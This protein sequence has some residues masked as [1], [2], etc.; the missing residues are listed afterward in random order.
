MTAK[1]SLSPLRPLSTS[2]VSISQVSPGGKRRHLNSVN[3][4]SL[5]SLSLPSPSA[6][7]IHSST[8]SSET[9]NLPLLLS[10]IK[11]TPRGELSH[12]HAFLLNFLKRD[13]LLGLPL[14]ISIVIL[15]QLDK[16][17]L[18]HCMMVCKQWNLLINNTPELWKRLIFRDSLITS[19]EEFESDYAALEQNGTKRVNIPKQMYKLRYTVLKRWMDPTFTPHRQVLEGPDLNVI[20]CLQFDNEKI[21]AGSNSCQILIYNTQSGEL[22]HT[23]LGH[24]GG[25]WAMKFYG[26]I[27]ASGSTDRTVR[28]WNTRTGKCTHIFKGHTSTVRCLEIVQPQ[29]IGT[30]VQGNP[31]MFPEE[32]MLVS[33]SRDATLYLWKLPINDSDSEAPWEFDVGENPYFVNVLK[34]HLASV[35]TVTAYANLVISGSYDSTVRVWDISTCECKYTL[36]GH[37][38]RIY[39]VVYDPHRHRCYSASVDNTVRIWD[40]ETGE[41]LHILEGH[42]ILVGLVTASRNALV[43]AAADSTVRVWD[44]DTGHARVVFRG[45]SGAITCVV[46]DDF[47][48]VSGSQGML[49]LW[50]VQTGKFVRDLVEGV[51]GSVWQVCIDWKRCVSAVQRGDVTVLEVLDFTKGLV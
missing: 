33:G 3:D 10:I 40:L 6:S 1:R 16:G 37:S 36:E 48:V 11:N 29:R 2:E 24:T 38:D 15:S 46:N 18:V 23:L 42:Q 21:A 22:I 41:C 14:E 39:S 17:D 44:Q 8:D 50:D 51:D 25:V 45:H 13:I 32:P 35:R 19:A 4:D 30:D 34:G 31:I 28:I 47:K 43:S 12:L 7:P 26:D 20:T 9:S 5:M 49:K 27:L